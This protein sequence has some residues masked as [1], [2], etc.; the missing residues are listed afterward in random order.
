MY[1]YETGER[2]PLFIK[3]K[4]NQ[5]MKTKLFLIL[6][7]IGIHFPIIIAQNEAI[8]TLKTWIE[9]L[10]SDD[11]KGRANGSVE[12]V[13]IADWIAK[14]FAN[15]GLYPLPHQNWMLQD[16]L[17]PESWTGF[18]SNV[19]GYIPGKSEDTYIVLSAHYDHIGVSGYKNKDNVYNGADDDASG[20]ALLL[21][22]AKKI[23]ERG[24]IPECS[25]VMIA[26]SGEEPGRL[27]SEYFC[28]SK[29]IPMEKVKFNL[30][31]ELVGRS[32]E[33]GKNKYYLT[34][35]DYSDLAS[36]LTKYNYTEQWQLN[37]LGPENNLLYTV[38]DNFSFVRYANR[39]KCCIPAHTLATSVGV[40]YIHQVQDEAKYIDYENLNSL[41]DY[42]TKLI[43]YLSWK[44]I[45][46]NCN[47]DNIMPNV[48]RQGN[49]R[50]FDE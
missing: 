35:P 37:Y 25:I 46:I 4:R 27:G 48:L 47:Y 50:P 12:N 38:S 34:G 13:K 5:I 15:C 40:G 21:G 28:Q 16:Y 6:C 32:T 10:S 29:I 14:K 26:F 44:D 36:V 45:I 43:F 17:Y 41:V 3:Q 23:Q 39:A 24:I 31:F 30:N 11:M 33:Y 7:L 1:F 20:I 9:F 42:T 49:E 2:M 18:L 19:V 8:D 22:I